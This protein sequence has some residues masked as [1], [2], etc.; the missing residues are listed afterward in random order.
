[1]RIA[2]LSEI[3]DNFGALEKLLVDVF[4]GLALPGAL[5]AVVAL[6]P[7]THAAARPS[8]ATPAVRAGGEAQI[9]EAAPDQSAPAAG[10]PTGPSSLADRLRE[11]AEGS[12]ARYDAL[13]SETAGFRRRGWF[14]SLFLRD[15]LRDVVI[16]P[17]EGGAGVTL[18]LSYARRD[19]EQRVVVG[20]AG[21]FELPGADKRFFCELLGA[22]ATAAPEM[23]HARLQFWFGVLRADGRMSWESRGGLG[24]AAAVARRFPPGSRTAEALWPLLDENSLYPS[25]WEAP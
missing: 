8:P 3:H 15:P 23:A 19:L 10:R 21:R 16:E 5:L 25:V 24:L 12:L 22:L 1:V 2:I 20:P 13:K 9:D 4:R 18:H 6:A 17:A 11:Y 14:P 7:P